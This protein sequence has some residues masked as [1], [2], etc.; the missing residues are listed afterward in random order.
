MPDTSWPPDPE[1]VSSESLKPPESL[2]KLI[3]TIL[4]ASDNRPS[5][6]SSIGRLVSSIAEDIVFN[7]LKG[8]VLQPKHLL[9][10]LGILNL[11][12]SRKVIDYL[13]KLGHC[14][15][16]NNV[17]DIETAQAEAVQEEAKSTS[18]LPFHP[19]IYEV[20]FSHFWIDNFDIF[21]DKEVGECSIHTTHMMA[22]QNVKPSDNV[23]KAK[24]RSIPKSKNRKI[25][26]EDVNVGSIAV[27]RKKNHSMNFQDKPDLC[28]NLSFGRKYLLW[29]VLRYKS[30][31]KQQIP[32]FKGWN[33]QQNMTDA[34]PIKTTE[35]Y[36][37]PIN[38]KVTEFKTIF[39]YLKYLQ[40][41]TSKMNMKYVHVSMDVGAAINCYLMIWNNPELFKNII[42]HLGSFHFLKENFQVRG[43]S[44]FV[45]YIR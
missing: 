13:H 41:L 39:K 1:I 25:F 45:L 14:I 4:R 19:S 44:F 5:R 16:Y 32:A 40:G 43:I 35:T 37:P 23:H 22:F 33:L 31:A 30:S 28:N 27:E 10:G 26:I 17:C 36:L 34:K 18:V 38:Y 24:T 2:L 7:S 3:E 29:I 15:A 42:V 8:A 11:T 21:T 9:L 20:L 12:G 6:S